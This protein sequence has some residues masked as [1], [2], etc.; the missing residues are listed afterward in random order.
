MSVRNP[1]NRRLHPQNTKVV[2]TATDR[3]QTV[4]AIQ[5]EKYWN[6]F[7]VNGF[8]CLV[9]NKM[10]QGRL[11]SC[12]LAQK[13]D[14][15]MPVFDEEGNASQSV[16]NTALQG[17]LQ[18]GISDYAETDSM[19]LDNGEIFS[20]DGKGIKRFPRK[21]DEDSAHTT[22]LVED[23]D[24]LEDFPEMDF[25]LAT[26]D[27]T[28]CGICYGSGF[29]GGFNLCFGNRFVLDTTY[30]TWNTIG[31]TASKDT[32]PYAFEKTGDENSYVD[33]IISLP[34]LISG[35][36]ALSVWENTQLINDVQIL[37]GLSVGTLTPVNKEN[38][39]LFCTG[40]PV[41]IRVQGVE[42]FTHLEIQLNLST[43]DTLLEYPR[44]TK[45]GD[46]NVLDATQDVQI[47]VSPKILEIQPWDII[48]DTTL[49]R[50]W[51]VTSINDWHDRNFN[52]QGWDISAR[53]VQRYETFS[54]LPS[55]TNTTQMMRTTRFNQF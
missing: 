48:V 53:L 37:A 54:F 10:R 2:K 18:F 26:L 19:Q 38:L 34:K 45:T 14:E 55:R 15:L 41:V 12:S 30:E 50:I 1:S 42:R 25:N 9:Y 7:A 20:L 17:G 31:Y 49:K 23:D 46:L 47:I 28:G 51:R 24:Y 43:E 13:R 11:C 22:E 16:I 5:Q 44:F 52:I 29:V 8:S 33:F 6:A 3:I 40:K 35:V 27:N 39:H 4:A 32:T 21:S 36:D